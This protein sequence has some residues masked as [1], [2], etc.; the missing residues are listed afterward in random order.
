MGDKQLL[1]PGAIVIAGIF[2]GMGLYFGLRASAG[3]S[4]P[5]SAPLPAASS[6]SV[7]ESVFE[8]PPPKRA[9]APA[10]A[11]NPSPVGPGVSP[12]VQDRV[13]KDAVKALERERKRVVKECWQPSAAASAEPASGTFRVRVGFGADGTLQSYSVADAE[14]TRRKD[15]ADCLRALKLDITVAP[16]GTFVATQLAL[17]L[18]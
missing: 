9:Q 16:P 15:V 11:A 13:T 18:P 10:E 1:L 12:E 7:E 3:A 4:T 8:S 17:K 5:A 2:I 14:D 6:A